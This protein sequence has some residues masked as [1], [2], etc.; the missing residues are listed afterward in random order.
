M[1]ESFISN[2]LNETFLNNEGSSDKLKLVRNDKKSKTIME[3][4][5]SFPFVKMKSAAIKEINNFGALSKLNRKESSSN[6][7]E[8]NNLNNDNTSDLNELEEYYY[9]ESQDNIEDNKSKNTDNDN[10][11]SHKISFSSGINSV[12]ISLK[13]NEEDK[14]DDKKEDKNKDKKEEIN[15]DD[16]K[17]KNKGKEFY[18]YFIQANYSN[19]LFNIELE[20]NKQAEDLK[21]VRVDLLNN[22]LDGAYI[23]YQLK[24]MPNLG[25][26]DL[27]LKFKLTGDNEINYNAEI[28]LKDFSHDCFFYDFKYELAKKKK[29][30][31]QI[32]N[33]AI[34]LNHYQQFKI[35]YNYIDDNECEIS[36]DVIAKYRK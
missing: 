23:I 12:E 15:A 13:G 21:K 24:I 25:I 11:Y 22:D 2:S 5:S 4:P 29:N 14:K 7:F 1:N 36:D 8:M 3:F 34:I 18:L 33:S 16:K 17:N 19:S 6:R 28:K 31:I 10:N 26:K 30:D 20:K 32:D 9:N 27:T 35:L